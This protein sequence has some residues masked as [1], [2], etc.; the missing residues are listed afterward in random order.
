M[1]TGDKNKAEGVVQ[2]W[3]V[4]FEKD[5]NK[6]AN[7]DQKTCKKKTMKGTLG[8]NSIISSLYKIN[9]CKLSKIRQSKS[10]NDSSLVGSKLFCEAVSVL[11][12]DVEHL[13]LQNEIQ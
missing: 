4:F 13:F 8:K 5:L 7:L 10:S 1:G 9:K 3:L 12:T 2:K 11:Q 6:I